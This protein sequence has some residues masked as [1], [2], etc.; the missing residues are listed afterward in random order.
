MNL[1]PLLSMHLP[2]TA[3]SACPA[4][5]RR[6]NITSRNKG[7]WMGASR[8]VAVLGAAFALLAHAADAPAS[9]ARNVLQPAIDERRLAGAVIL[10][11]TK[12]RVLE[13]EALGFADVKTRRSMRKDALFWI[14]ST[15]KPFVST[16]VMMLVEQGRLDLDKPVTDYLPDFRPSLAP[17]AGQTRS[18][19]APSHHVKAIAL[20]H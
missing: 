8:T 10:I 15:S 19:Y 13:H 2:Q 12:D 14:A 20:A 18:A 16:A 1:K 9:V 4:K 6:R 7:R 5:S 17:R 3:F 11:E